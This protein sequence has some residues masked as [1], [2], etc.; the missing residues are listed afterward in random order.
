MNRKHPALPALVTV[1]GVPGNSP[2]TSKLHRPRVLMLIPQLG[3]G[4]AE[5]AFLRLADFLADKADVTIG[6]MARTYGDGPYSDAGSKTDLPVVMLDEG[7][8]VG[9]SAIGKV[10]RWW[11][12]LRRVR[13]LKQEC[14]V[15]IS[16]MSGANF[17]NAMAGFPNKTVVSE[18]GSKFH[19]SDLSVLQRWLWTRVLDPLIYRRAWRVVAAS[20][21]LSEELS[22]A[23]PRVAAR[24]FALEGTLQADRLLRTVDTETDAAFDWLSACET[25]VAYGRM[26]PQKGFDLLLQAFASVRRQRNHA[27]LLLVGDGPELIRLK[28]LA[29]ALGLRHGVAGDNDVDVVF[30][31]YQ[32]A[33]LRFLRLGK[34]F[35]FPSRTEGLPNALMEALAS[36]VPIL[37]SDC[38]WGPRSVLSGAEDRLEDCPTIAPRHLAY[39]TLMPV[40][41]QADAVATWAAELHRV[42]AAPRI[43]HPVEV[44]EKAV[45]RFDIEV[46][47]P[48]WLD[49]VLEVSGCEP[50]QPVDKAASTGAVLG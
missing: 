3:Y 10:R 32:P 21:G 20:K 35:A 27:R 24:I 47:G 6:L 29:D 19:A 46:T 17:L 34:V 33:P 9:G 1:L 8:V 11:R 16:F 2:S 41:D 28:A 37:A 25:V 50:M 43:R 31:G 40:P 12:M 38:P 5:G 15:A 22:L 30:A 42:L 39:G 14:D 36:G 7:E 49:L 48:R 18:R 26:H 13:A 45:R 4:G 44:R 23:N